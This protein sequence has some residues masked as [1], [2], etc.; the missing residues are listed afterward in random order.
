MMFFLYY[1]VPSAAPRELTASNQGPGTVFLSWQPPPPEDWNGILTDYVVTI[2]NA[3]SQT[4]KTTTNETSITLSRL[5][6][7][8]MHNFTVAATTSVGEGPIAYFV[9]TIPPDGS[10]LQFMQ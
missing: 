4:L 3:A 1:T 10:K 5:R 7:L 2:L 6:R 8:Q 9:L